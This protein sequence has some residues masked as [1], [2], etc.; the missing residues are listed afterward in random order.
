VTRQRFPQPS[1]SIVVIIDRVDEEFLLFALDP[2]GSWAHSRKGALQYG[3]A[4]A[5]LAELMIDG[6][7]KLDRRK[8]VPRS[9]TPANEKT[10]DWVLGEVRDKRPKAVETWVVKLGRKAPPHVHDVMLRLEGR[11]HV[12]AVRKGGDF[13]YPVRDAASRR[14]LRD[15]L[16]GV[17]FGQ[18]PADESTTLL[19]AVLDAAGYMPNVFG[20]ELDGQARLLFER[21]LHKDPRALA[22]H[23]AIL[24][25]KGWSLRSLW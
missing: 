9:H 2:D 11:G 10:L 19:L 13:R 20:R 3:L 6:Y 14:A 8:V 25:T 17:L 22:L 23:E 5:W 18:Y 15:H 16:K 21:I 7:L 1:Q 24:R 12:Q 4:G